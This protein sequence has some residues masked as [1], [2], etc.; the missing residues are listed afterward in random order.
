VPFFIACF[1]LRLTQSSG[2]NPNAYVPFVTAGVSFQYIFFAAMYA[3]NA[4]S[5]DFSCVIS[6][7]ESAT[8]LAS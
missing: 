1:W 5:V 3:F 2:I 4:F 7:A 8:R 6:S